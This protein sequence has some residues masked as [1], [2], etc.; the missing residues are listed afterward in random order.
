MRADL[1]EDICG[2]LRTVAADVQTSIALNTVLVRTLATLSG[3][4]GV[5]AA[6]ALED[7]AAEAQR[8]QAPART[9]ECL[10]CLQSA[11]AASQEEESLA[12]RMEQALIRAADQLKGAEGTW[13]SALRNEPGANAA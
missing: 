4:C 13:A 12:R 11:L 9:L 2:L 1:D 7:A 8:R 3:D 10:T 6:T 5:A